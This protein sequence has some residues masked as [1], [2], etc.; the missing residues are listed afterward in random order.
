MAS[1]TSVD[2]DTYDT[3][4]GSASAQRPV[5]VSADIALDPLPASANKLV[6]AISKSALAVEAASGQVRSF[7]KGTF[8]LQLA[9]VLSQS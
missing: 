6:R 2:Q 1:L 7:L 9:V 5:R 4:T 8:S 3:G